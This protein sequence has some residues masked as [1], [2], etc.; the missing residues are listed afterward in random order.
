MNHIIPHAG[1]LFIGYDYRAIPD[2]KKK[3]KKK[4]KG[5][6]EALIVAVCRFVLSC[7][8][9]SCFDCFCLLVFV[10][11]LFWLYDFD[12]RLSTTKPM[13]LKYDRHFGKQ[14]EFTLGTPEETE[15]IELAEEEERINCRWSIDPTV[16]CQNYQCW[17]GTAGEQTDSTST[18]LVEVYSSEVPFGVALCYSFL[19]CSAGGR[20]GAL[21]LWTTLKISFC[22]FELSEFVSFWRHWNQL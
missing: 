4:K 9:L 16:N 22:P 1:T 12:R 3:E 18:I 6:E 13:Y 2:V 10:F 20:V 7:F 5:K 11:L 21:Q 19:L 14:T 17:T 8:I 15:Q